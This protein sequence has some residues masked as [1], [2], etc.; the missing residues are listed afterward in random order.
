M[1]II[2]QY[3]PYPNGPHWNA[4]FYS[5]KRLYDNTYQ[6]RFNGVCMIFLIRTGRACCTLHE[7]ICA[8]IYIY[9]GR[10]VPIHIHHLWSF[11]PP[12]S[13]PIVCYFSYKYLAPP[14]IEPV[15]L[16]FIVRIYK[17]GA[18]RRKPIS[19]YTQSRLKTVKFNRI[20]RLIFGLG[21]AGKIL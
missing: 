18:I 14:M 10:S 1:T 8:Y 20:H 16:S 11:P 4:I 6:W 9:T 2:N 5:L 21:G 19:S 13:I 15:N 17:Y 12:I 3:I 7:E